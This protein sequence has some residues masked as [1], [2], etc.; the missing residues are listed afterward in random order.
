MYLAACLHN[1]A[2][3]LTHLCKH[4]HV[5]K[6]RC[7]P[8]NIKHRPPTTMW[9]EQIESLSVLSVINQEVQTCWMQLF[10]FVIRCLQLEKMCQETLRPGD[11]GKTWESTPLSQI[12][13]TRSPSSGVKVKLG[14]MNLTGQWPNIVLSW[15]Y[16]CVRIKKALKIF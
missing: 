10:P 1:L 3:E 2:Q 12:N 14:I 6:H 8:P 13:E 9:L 11:K 7:T 4:T 16:R 5:H 15:W